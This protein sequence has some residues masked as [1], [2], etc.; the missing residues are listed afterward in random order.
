MWYMWTSA[1]QLVANIKGKNLVSPQ[2]RMSGEEC[3]SF[4]NAHSKVDKLWDSNLYH[5]EEKLKVLFMLHVL[6]MQECTHMPNGKRDRG[7]HSAILLREAWVL[8]NFFFEL[9][10]TH[11]LVARLWNVFMWHSLEIFHFILFIFYRCSQ[12]HSICDVEIVR[13]KEYTCSTT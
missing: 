10:W 9:L 6:S 13:W 8:P 4:K 1:A 5:T 12:N 7:G 3:P 2:Y 11:L